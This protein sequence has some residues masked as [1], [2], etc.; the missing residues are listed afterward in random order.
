M[1]TFKRHLKVSSGIQGDMTLLQ[2]RIGG[3]DDEYDRP[4]VGRFERNC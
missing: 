1:H 2:E 3:V 4:P